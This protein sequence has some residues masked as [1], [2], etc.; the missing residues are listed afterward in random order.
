MTGVRQLIFFDG[1]CSLCN[2]SIDFVMRRDKK[3][4]FLVGALQDGISKKILSSYAVKKDYLDSLVLLQHGQLYY[5]STAALKIAR[6]LSG[7]WPILYPLIYLPGWLRDSVYNW[8]SKNRYKWFGKSD[9]CR[10]PSPGE[11]ARFLT[12]ETARKY[13]LL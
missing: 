4:L 6:N 13:S 10:L 2:A 9:T 5:R 8:I 7:P 1:V 11:K 12:A 3:H